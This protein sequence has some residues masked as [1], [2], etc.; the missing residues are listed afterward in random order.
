MEA[1][2]ADAPWR[3]DRH[4]NPAGE[5]GLLDR[6]GRQAIW[7]GVAAATV[8]LPW[9]LLA[10]GR[11]DL[12]PPVLV[13]AADLLPAFLLGRAAW[14][15]RAWRRRGRARLRFDRFPFFLGEP[16][17][18][19]LRLDPGLAM[20]GLVEVTLACRERRPPGGAA[21]GWQEEEVYRSTQV[22]PAAPET[23]VAFELP[24][25][26]RELGTALAAPEGR[27]WELR[28]NG[29]SGTPVEERFPVPVY[30][31]PVEGEP[32]RVR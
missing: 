10:A 20:E 8:L 25:A 19:R 30:A 31:P 23:A 17:E 11:P 18:A 29:R 12:V 15:R 9:N 4:W 5:P 24:A 13:V 3:T 16:F 22:L 1:A 26:D 6:R 7:W 28:V 32:P 27:H 14:L 2:A 21:G